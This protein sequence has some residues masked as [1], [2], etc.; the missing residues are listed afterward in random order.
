[1]AV[2]RNFYQVNIIVGIIFIL[3]LIGSELGYKG[4]SNSLAILVFIFGLS[5]VRFYVA[6]FE[7]K[8]LKSIYLM[9]FKDESSDPIR[10][11]AAD[12]S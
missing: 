2:R 5:V 3:D 11:G 10:P 12:N 6:D 9:H 7:I 8:I 1:M 4:I